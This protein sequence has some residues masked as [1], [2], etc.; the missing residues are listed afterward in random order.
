MLHFIATGHA[1]EHAKN[2]ESWHCSCLACRF[3]KEFKIPVQED[4]G[5]L[6]DA[7]IAEAVLNSLE[8][9]GYHTQIDAVVS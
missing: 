7:T 3:T 4:D 6:R 8:Q 2:K 1:L 9:Q 5:T